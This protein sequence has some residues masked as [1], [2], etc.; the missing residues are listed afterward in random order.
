MHSRAQYIKK[1]VEEGFVYDYKN[2]QYLYSGA[3]WQLTG[4]AGKTPLPPDLDTF[5]NDPANQFFHEVPT[6]NTIGQ[7]DIPHEMT[8]QGSPGFVH[9]LSKR[10]V[11]PVYYNS[12]GKHMKIKLS[13]EHPYKVHPNVRNHSDDWYE[14]EMPKY[15]KVFQEG[16]WR[17]RSKARKILKKHAAYVT[18]KNAHNERFPNALKRINKEGY[19]YQRHVIK[20]FYKTVSPKEQALEKTLRKHGHITE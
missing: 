12:T 18:A 15:D 7:H 6:W 17:D 4:A 14:Q 19:D 9:P 8:L 13:E 2:P 1:I 16:T 5:T 20:D 10:Q 11:E 3:W